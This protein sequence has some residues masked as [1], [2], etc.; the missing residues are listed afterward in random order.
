[1]K[2]AYH[3]ARTHAVIRPL[4][5]HDNVRTRTHAR[6][7]ALPSS[8]LRQRA[9]ARVVCI[10]VICGI[11]ERL[12]SASRAVTVQI[13]ALPCSMIEERRR[14]RTSA[15]AVF[16]LDYVRALCTCARA[17]NGITFLPTK[18]CSRSHIFPPTLRAL[19]VRARLLIESARVFLIDNVRVYARLHES[20]RPR[21]APT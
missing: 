5:S 21:F 3:H 9:R 8:Y 15:Q 10:C 4:F 1:M 11:S 13:R 12:Q 7:T 17:E 19:G 2:H 16:V 20:F 14:G 6:G 18:K